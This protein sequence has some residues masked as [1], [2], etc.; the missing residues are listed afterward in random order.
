MRHTE[1]IRDIIKK[2]GITQQELATKL[3]FAVQSSVAVYLSRR[4]NATIM[5]TVDMLEALDYEMVVRPISQEPLGPDE[6][7]L[8]SSDYE[9]ET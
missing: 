6:Y 7:L 9:E 3:G 5:S 1:I 8:R 2:E 4:R